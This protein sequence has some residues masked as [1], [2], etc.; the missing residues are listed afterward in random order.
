LKKLIIV[1]TGPFAEIA[2]L[3][4]EVYGGYKVSAF[5]VEA[6]FIDKTV[7]CN[8]PVVEFEKVETIYDPDDFEI[9]VAITYIYLNRTRTRL[10]SECKRKG[11]KPA[12]FIS[13]YAF[14]GLET[15]IGEHCFVFENNVIQPFV[16][17]SSNVILW[18]GNHIGHHS[19]IL[20]NCFISS[21]VVIS[22]FC[23]IGEYS[24]IGINS[25]IANNV[26]IGND[27]WI[28]PN[29]N[30]LKNTEDGALYKAQEGQPAKISAPQFF[31][32]SI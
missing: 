4:F 24:F 20:S 28:S 1:G 12:S 2:K 30:I 31:K 27:N 13:P 18:S 26:S 25:T 32:V 11:F 10:L 19:T 5:A 8:L 17:I 21:H 22:G 23:Q 6:K 9:F 16:K 7:F 29:V 14:V 15:E 3:Y